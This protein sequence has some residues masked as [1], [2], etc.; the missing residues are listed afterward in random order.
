[1]ETD[2]KVIADPESLIQVPK[3]MRQFP[4][5]ASQARLFPTKQNWP[6]C[7]NRDILSNVKS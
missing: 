1:M 5:E 3:Q 6:I 4:G 7:D 2:S